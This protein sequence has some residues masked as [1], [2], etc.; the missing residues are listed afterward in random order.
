M[1]SEKESLRKQALFVSTKNAKR[2]TEIHKKA[3]EQPNRLL[4]ARLIDYMGC[5]FTAPL[6]KRITVSRNVYR[7]RLHHCMSESP[8]IPDN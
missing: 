4:P 5:F 8:V 7:C 1:Q 6:N 2:R 3:K